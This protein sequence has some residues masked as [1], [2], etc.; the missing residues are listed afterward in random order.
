MRSFLLLLAALV[1]FAA[2]ARAVN[3]WGYTGC[4][5]GRKL[6][7]S[8]RI[9]FDFDAS[10][11]P[12]TTWFSVTAPTA[13]ACLRPDVATIGAK[14][15]QA[16]LYYCPTGDPTSTTTCGIQVGVTAG[17]T[18]TGANGDPSS[19]LACAV[20]GPGAYFLDVTALPGGGEVGLF[21]VEGGR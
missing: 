17:V 6:G 14:T 7:E 2:P 1:A 8:G 18:L 21:T 12:A 11:S 4:L 19:Q 10:L 13:L 16:V 5:D 9:C 15:A 20:V 3:D